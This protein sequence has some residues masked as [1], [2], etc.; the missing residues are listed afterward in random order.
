MTF[1]SFVICTRNSQR[2][3]SEVISSIITQ[4]SREDR[5]EVILVDYKSTD[6]TIQIAQ[7][8]LHETNINLV[9]SNCDLPGK[10]PALIKGFNLASGEY[11]VVVDDDNV[12]ASS[13]ITNAKKIIKD[14]SVGCVGAMGIVDHELVLP[15][16]FKKYQGVYAVGMPENKSKSVDSVWGAGALLKKEAWDKLYKNKFKFELNPARDSHSS[17]IMIGGEDGEISVAIKMIGYKIFYS[18]RL[19][20]IHK[21]EQKRL[22][23][24]YLLQN[25]FGSTRAVPII[26]IYRLFIHHNKSRAPYLIW[27]AITVKRIM[28]SYIRVLIYS[29]LG[30]GLEVKYHLVRGRALICGYFDAKYSFNIIHKRL[31]KILKS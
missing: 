3:L 10:S 16:W 1:F 27:T 21:F 19:Q 8:V 20:F 17:P 15:L 18:D 13:Y 29:I 31:K 25:T 5:F 28:G 14:P 11:I 9:I 23:E 26:D 4:T 24:D 7:D 30:N 6:Q 22:T 2:I 12:L